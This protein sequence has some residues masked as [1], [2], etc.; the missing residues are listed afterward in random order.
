MADWIAGVDGCRKGWVAAFL[1]L[2]SGLFEV[3]VAATFTDVVDAPEAPRVVAVDIPIGL[4]DR[5]EGPGRAAERAVRRRLGARRSSVFSMPSRSA[6]EAYPNGYGAVCRLARATSHPARAISRQGFHILP[7]VLEVDRLLRARPA[8]ISAVFEV[9]PEAAF[10]C[11]NGDE[12]LQHAKST[13]EGERERERLLLANGIPTAMLGPP[14]AG[15]RRDDLIDALAGVAVARAIASG[16]GRPHPDRFERD[17]HGLPIAIWTYHS[18]AAT[19][20]AG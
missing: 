16:H 14:P 18:K 20:S 15:A 4:P 12:P 1:D 8:L 5:I 10:W 9:H 3:R 13:G 11:L 17:A 6:A 19:P 7:K 2:D